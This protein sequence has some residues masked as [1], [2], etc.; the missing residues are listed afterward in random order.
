MCAAPQPEPTGY[1]L[2]GPPDLLH[3]LQRDFLDI[4]WEA[5]VVRWQA[6]VTAPPEDAGH[7]PPEW[8]AEITLAGVDRTPHRVSVAEFLG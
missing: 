6:V 8:P 4:G 3:D 5:T 2:I 7:T 1:R